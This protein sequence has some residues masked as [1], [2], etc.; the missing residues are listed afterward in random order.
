MDNGI[1]FP[2]EVGN[3]FLPDLV[4]GSPSNLSSGYRR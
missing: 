1:P 3:G 4:W 2:A